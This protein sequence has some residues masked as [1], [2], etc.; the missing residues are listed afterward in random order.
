MSI[1]P[2][3]APLTSYACGTTCKDSFCNVDFLSPIKITRAESIPTFERN[4]LELNLNDNL[5]KA[6]FYANIGLGTPGAAAGAGGGG[7]DNIIIFTFNGGTVS[8]NDKE[9]SLK[10]MYMFTPGVHILSTD[11]T[12]NARAGVE[13]VLQFETYEQKNPE[14]LNISIFGN[15]GSSFGRP[16]QFFNKI[17][18]KLSSNS[19]KITTIPTIPLDFTSALNLY[20][21]LPKNRSYFS[22]TGS[23][24]GGKCMTTENNAKPSKMNDVNWIVFENSIDIA[25]A[26]LDYLKDK[27]VAKKG[28]VA[29][30]VGLGAGHIKGTIQYPAVANADKGQYVYY[31]KDRDATLAGMESGDVKYVKCSKRVMNEDPDAYRKYLY[32]KKNKGRQCDKILDMNKNLEKHFDEKLNKISDENTL[33]GQLN[34]TFEDQGEKITTFILLLFIFVL[35][36]VAAYAAVYGIVASIKKFKDAGGWQNMKDMTAPIVQAVQVE[37]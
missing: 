33:L 5:S 14:Y 23:N 20:D 25:S 7:G 13:I 17:F 36:F 8:F 1:K 12:S 2:A 18:G 28:T 34:K 37:P 22:Y 15:A 11:K 4:T 19:A 6:T 29:A 32:N 27:P 24:F 10:R 26:D 31:K 21:I 3:E 30:T 16:A 9:Y 35:L